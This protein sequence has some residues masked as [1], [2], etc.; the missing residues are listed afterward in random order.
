VR[1]EFKENNPRLDFWSDHQDWARWR[2]NRPYRAATWGAMTGWFVSGDSGGEYYDYGGDIYYEDGEVYQDGAAV[3]TADEYAQQADQ[4]ADAGGAAID[5]A[6]ASNADLELMPLGVFALSSEDDEEP[7]M[8]IQLA[9]SKNGLI[10][11]TYHN[12]LT[13]QTLPVQGSVDGKTQRAAWSI[14]DKRNTVMET[15]I[16]NLTEDQTPVLIHFG[17]ENTQ[18]WLM[19]RLEEPEQPDSSQ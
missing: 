11:G 17:G 10:S 4:I 12:L 19:V 5:D 7:I 14:G 2:Y 1:D 16:F 13:E 8:C 15:G 6:I 9:V 18:Q 3:A